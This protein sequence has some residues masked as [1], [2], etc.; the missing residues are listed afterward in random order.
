MTIHRVRLLLVPCLILGT[1]LPSGC[2]STSSPSDAQGSDLLADQGDAPLD[3][4]LSDGSN[5]D[6]PSD[7]PS[8]S[9]VPADAP[10]LGDRSDTD[11]ETPPEWPSQTSRV[12]T[13]SILEYPGE[14][15]SSVIEVSLWSLPIFYAYE[16][17]EAADS[18]VL[19]KPMAQGTCE[20]PCD[21]YGSYCDPKT[22]TCKVNPGR[23]DAGVIS[24]SGLNGAG[25]GATATPD[26]SAWYTVAPAS[27]PA[28]L[29]DADSR[30]TVS[31]A[32]GPDV[33]AFE[34]H[35]DGV[36][37]MKV[38]SFDYGIVL[39]NDN[40]NVISWEVQNDSARI[41]LLLQAGWHGAPPAGI[42]YCVADDADGQ[43]VLPQALV[44]KFPP[45]GAIGLFQHPSMISRVD[46]KEVTTEAG[47]VEVLLS[48]QFGFSVEH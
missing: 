46:R 44:K 38:T 19:L 3:A 6:V 30:I 11:V 2:S 20:P 36:G 28:N 45:I 23:L 1:A 43:I 17:V 35:L 31:G 7:L 14:Y 25:D 21:T 5:P 22:N 10:D 33:P 16:L 26:E 32:G 29:F 27:L 37:D 8:D 40:P 47:P 48:S 13:I 18:C 42:L 9:L 34:I 12:G 39:D 41:E 24:F 15:A 4:D